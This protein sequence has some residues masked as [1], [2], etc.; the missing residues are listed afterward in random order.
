M[1]AERA[2]GVAFLVAGLLLATFSDH[3]SIVAPSV[4]HRS[5]K[6]LSN[7]KQIGLAFVFYQQENGEFLPDRNGTAFV[8]HLYE[9]GILRDPYV[10]L[11][12]RGRQTPATGGALDERTCSYVGRRNTGEARLTSRLI[13]TFGSRTALAADRS[14]DHHPD[15]RYVLFADGHAEEVD[16]ERYQRHYASA[17]GD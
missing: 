13:S 14:A 12:P 15:L 17:M 11:C 7:L 5:R 16:E 1:R 4:R 2:A 6:C 8:S 9:A 3:E 10:Y